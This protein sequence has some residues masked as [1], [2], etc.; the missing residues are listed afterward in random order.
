[1]DIQLNC[2]YS[3]TKCPTS[4]IYF[5]D[6]CGCVGGFVDWCSVISGG[7][8][9]STD[10]SILVARSTITNPA[11]GQVDC[12]VNLTSALSFYIGTQSGL[13]KAFCPDTVVPAQ[14]TVN[15]T[16]DGSV[17]ITSVPDATRP[18]CHNINFSTA[19]ASLG[20]AIKVGCQG[21]PASAF[22]TVQNTGGN[23]I[24]Q[25]SNCNILS[26]VASKS[27]PSLAYNDTITLT[28][29]KNLVTS[30]GQTC[31]NAVAG[32]TRAIVPDNTGCLLTNNTLGAV[33][34][35]GAWKLGALPGNFCTNGYGYNIPEFSDKRDFCAWMTL[36]ESYMRFNNMPVAGTA[37]PA[38]VD[39]DALPLG[40]PVYATSMD[41]RDY[42]VTMGT[43][44]APF[45]NL[46]GATL[47]TPPS[48]FAYFFFGSFHVNVLAMGITNPINERIQVSIVPLVN[49]SSVDFAGFDKQQ[50]DGTV[51]SPIDE[52]LRFDLTTSGVWSIST[53]GNT[54]GMRVEI[55]TSGGVSN[56]VNFTIGEIQYSGVV[57]LRKI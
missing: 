31:D 47:S 41:R 46:N 29:P 44:V 38:V 50:S 3:Y 7:Y 40:E 42:L 37:S 5:S 30:I 14:R 18:G 15:F 35:G 10:G 16:S 45:L 1:M 55:H 57:L 49:G 13:T 25:S 21:D 34:T 43:G 6:N 27:A 2:G 32:E 52:S 56:Y 39:L 28:L 12:A 8:I 23:I 36:I 4:Q 33:F 48:G 17:D 22:A 19:T 54:V 26:I 9:T 20:K 24:L 11:T 53:A 51:T